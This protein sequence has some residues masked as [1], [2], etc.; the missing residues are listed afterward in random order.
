MYFIKCGGRGR[1]T[2]RMCASTG[3]QA[4][5]IR[6]SRI[7][8]LTVVDTTPSLFWRPNTKCV[9]Q[10]LGLLLPFTRKLTTV[11]V[12]LF[13]TIYLLPTNRLVLNSAAHAV[14]KT[15][16]LY[17]ITPILKSPHWLKYMILFLPYINF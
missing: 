15:P 3:H 9:R 1:Q 14:A 11:D 12:I 10:T 5:K 13:Y 2:Q 16:T 4:L 17:H 8:F 6:G 7:Y